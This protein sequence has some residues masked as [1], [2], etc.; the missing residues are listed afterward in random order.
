[1]IGYGRSGYAYSYFTF[2]SNTYDAS[3]KVREEN[4]AFYSPSS[5][6]FS[7]GGEYNAF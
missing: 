6:R 4:V 3:L 1:M 7:R 5:D 2:Y